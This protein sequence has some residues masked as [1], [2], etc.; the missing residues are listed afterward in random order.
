[1]TSTRLK[2]SIVYPDT[3][4]AP[5][6]ES[7]IARDYLIYSVETLSLYFQERKDVYVSGN[8]FIYNE[9]GVP[10]AVVAPDAFVIFGVSNRQRMSYK[11]WEEG[12]KMPDFILEITSSSTR[13]QD[14]VE[15]PQKYARMRVAEY[16]QYDPSGDYLQP[17]LKGSHL[18]EGKYQPM[19]AE[20][21][22]E[23]ILSIHSQVLGLDLRLVEGKLRFYEPQT[24][25]K[26]LSYKEIE[27]AR[28][29]AESARQQAEQEREAEARSRREAI[30]RLMEMGLSLEQVAAALGLS[31][32]EVSQ[33]IE[34]QLG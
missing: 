27:L 8:L 17:Q 12:G 14:Q 28:Q 21:R 20:V 32:Q 33:Y 34:S 24:G 6:A 3:D 4:G 11:V 2:T 26:L 18:V 23:G 7:D 22:E 1:M 9:K 31:V 30:P 29:Q 15:K 5:M 19:Q 13:N 16:F 10:D 25:K